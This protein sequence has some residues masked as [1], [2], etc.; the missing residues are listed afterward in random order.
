MVSIYFISVI[1]GSFRVRAYRQIGLC[2]GNRAFLYAHLQ[3]CGQV[4]V[5]SIKLFNFSFLKHHF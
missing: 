4:R 3:T 5:I 2:N 1:I